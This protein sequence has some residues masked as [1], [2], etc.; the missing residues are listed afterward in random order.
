MRK[1][2]PMDQCKNCD[3]YCAGFP[4]QDFSY[5]NT[6]RTGTSSYRGQAYHLCVDRIKFLKP[7]RF[8][9]ENVPAF[10]NYNNGEL[11]K[12][13]TQNLREAG[14]KV[15]SKVLNAINFSVPQN[16]KRLFIV[17]IRVDLDPGGF[18]FPTGTGTTN[19][20][21]ILDPPCAGDRAFRLQTGQVAK[22][23]V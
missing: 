7:K 8:I 14:Y 17:G 6:S 16:R 1:L 3:L 19:L 2:P 10:G 13:F 15:Y 20:D 4:C 21:T 9:F 11:L 23:H 12:T 5:N 22:R 18:R